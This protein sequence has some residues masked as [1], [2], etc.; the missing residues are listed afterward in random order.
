MISKIKPVIG[1]CNDKEKRT[2][3]FAAKELSRYLGMVDHAGDFPVIPVDTYK[4][5]ADSIYLVIGHEKLPKVEDVYYDDAIYVQVDGFSGTISGTNARATLI[6]MYRFL[7]GKGYA[8]I[9]PGRHGETIPETLTDAPVSLCEAASYRHRGLC[10]EGTMYEESFEEILDWLPKVGMN[11]YF[12]QFLE[13]GDHLRRYYQNY[14]GY[15]LNN[16]EAA[17]MTWMIRDAIAKRS[18]LYH[19]TGHGWTGEVIGTDRH[20]L[21]KVP[22]HISEETYSMLAELDGKRDVFQG[23]PLN[24]NLC[25]SN[26]KVQEKMTDA[27]MAY[28]SDHEGIDYLH[29]WVADGGNN[30]CECAECVKKRSSDFYVQMLNLLDEKMTKAGINT[31]VVFLIYS[32]LVWAPSEER[33]KNP[34]R[35]SMMWAP[36]IRWFTHPITPDMMDTPVLPYDLNGRLYNNIPFIPRDLSMHVAFYKDWRGTFDGDAFDFDYHFCQEYLVDMSGYRLA[37][38]IHADMVVFEE[39][40]LNGLIDCQVQRV[41][42]PTAL[43][44]NVQAETLWNRNLSFDEIAERVL[45]LQFGEKYQAVWDYLKE[46]SLYD[47]ARA[48]HEAESMRSPENQEKLEKG[49]KLIRAFRQAH[50]AYVAAMPAGNQKHDWEGL[51]FYGEVHEAMFNCY[52]A[53][54]DEEVKALE[55]IYNETVKKKADQFKSEF[56]AAAMALIKPESMLGFGY[57][58]DVR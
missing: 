5:E 50:E 7:R 54:S 40:G 30:M 39:I 3:L 8:F 53:Q 44:M 17:G 11:A 32:G 2:L 55:E 38:V 41:F 9:K 31:K 29:F 56:D 22:E 26:R 43:G 12:I 51:L 4:E 15:T 46:L 25:Y 57:Q 45:K 13:P 49:I 36:F 20:Y 35:F 34:D 6:A 1:T 19:A 24:T 14:K 33:I 37:K 52:R 21:R 58:S 48:V 47:V 23:N 16:E 28:L 10:F 18:L 42:L 27:I